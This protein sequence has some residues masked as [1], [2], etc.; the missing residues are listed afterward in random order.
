MG[1]YTKTNLWHPEREHLTSSIEHH[2][3]QQKQGQPLAKDEALPEPHQ[4]IDTPIGK[5]GIV[6]C[7]DIAFP[8]AFRSLIQA[9]AKII[10]A[11]TF[12]VEGDMIEEGRKYNSRAEE[13]FLRNTLVSRAFEN[14]CAVIFCNAGGPASDGFIGISQVALPIVGMVKPSFENSEEGFR[15]VEV[16]MD[17]VEIAEKNYKIRE[18]LSRKDWHYGYT[19]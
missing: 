2:G 19:K 11:P 7:W 17:I 8:E 14:T 9:G 16:D 6:V 12:W 1:Q 3:Q 15:V 10:L 13:L 4:V 18:D 5:V